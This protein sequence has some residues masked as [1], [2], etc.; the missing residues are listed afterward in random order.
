[1]NQ[2]TDIVHKIYEALE[3]GKEVRMVFLDLAKRLIKYGI[4]FIV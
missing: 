4:R 2:L 3:I 1:V